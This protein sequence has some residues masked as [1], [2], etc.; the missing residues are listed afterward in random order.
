VIKLYGE[1]GSKIKEAEKTLTEYFG[2]PVVVLDGCDKYDCN[3][4]NRILMID[5][6]Q[7][8]GTL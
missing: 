1:I 4:N 6:K 7:V 3:A 8:F 5:G 2:V